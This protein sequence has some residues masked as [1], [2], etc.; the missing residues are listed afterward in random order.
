M[1]G[2]LTLIGVIGFYY[3]REHA[4]TVI[5]LGMFAES[6][7]GVENAEAYTVIDGAIARFEEENPGIKV[8]YESGVCRADYT[9]WLSRKA[10]I[11][12]TPDVFMVISEDFYKLASLEILENLD[13][14]IVNDKSFHPDYFYPSTLNMGKRQGEQYAL[15]YETVP[16]MMFVN[17]T[18][19]KNEGVEV[20]ENTW[21]WEDL[22]RITEQV[23]KDNDG[24]GSLDQYGI[25]NYTW[26]DGVYANGGTLF[27][28]GGS[29]AYF[30]DNQVIDA[31]RFVNTL[32][33]LQGNNE[34]SYL[35]FDA[36]KV[37]FMPLMFANYRTYKTYPYRIKQFT[38]FQWDCITMPAGPKGGNYSELD[39]LLMGMASTS[40]H[41][42]EAWKFLKFLTSDS[43][44]QRKLFKYSQGAS[45]L[46]YVSGSRYIE[47]T[48]RAD[49]DANEKV[50]DA[51]LLDEAIKK[52]VY[53]HQFSKYS[54]AMELADGRIGDMLSNEKNIESSMKVLQQD[55]TKFIR[56]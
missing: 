38:G 37:A 33:E 4:T 43:D 54:Q 39:T 40:A 8:E 27:D 22:K 12:E 42:D 53:Q 32:D 13:N 16:K 2:L 51:D 9:E 21:T 44:T 14:R 18:L 56:N 36:G 24:N 17:K 47:S 20:P 11:G 49:V 46:K 41:K 3:R 50:I 45:V 26:K 7:W 31:V 19:L 48:I 10:L 30:S 29:N 25:C 1:A 34:V 52:G 35:D 55:I 5:H 6:N 15:P 23:T 28:E